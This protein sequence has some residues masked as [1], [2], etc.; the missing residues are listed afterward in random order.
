MMDPFMRHNTKKNAYILS[1]GSVI[2]HE[3]EL[4]SSER[5]GVSQVRVKVKFSSEVPEMFYGGRKYAVPKKETE[6]TQDWVWV[7][8][9]WYL[10][11]KDLFGK[12]Y[13][14]L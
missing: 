4:L 3:Y 11:F 9:N 10:L 12:T 6:A 2:Y 8:G 7:D 5:V 14:E 13:R 1:Q